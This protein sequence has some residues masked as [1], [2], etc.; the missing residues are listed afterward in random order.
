MFSSGCQ[1]FSHCS[2][3]H[4][5]M[6]KPLP[7]WHSLVSD[8]PVYHPGPRPTNQA[9]GHCLGIC[10]YILTS[11]YFSFHSKWM[12]RCVTCRSAYWED[13]PFSLSLKVTHECGYNA[14]LSVFSWL[15][16]TE[17]TQLDNK[18]RLLPPPSTNHMRS[19]LQPQAWAG[20]WVLLQL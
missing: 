9:T 18:F 14:A 15:Q 10:I 5:S 6:Y 20:R 3:S 7:D 17:S 11:C 12:T 19:S 2:H 16:H 4:V 1:I 13:F 8:L